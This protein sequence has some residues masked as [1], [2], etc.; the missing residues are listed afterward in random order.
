LN[1]PASSPLPSSFRDPSGHLFERDGVLY[2]SVA[3]RYAAH[4]DRLMSSGLYDRLVEAQL[5]VPHEE[6]T[7]SADAHRVLRPQRIPFVSYP[8]EW[9]FG[10]LRHAALATLRIQTLALEHGMSL[11]DASAYNIQFRDAKPCL[12]DTLSFEIRDEPRP[13]IAYRQFCEHFLAPLALM[14]QRD[15]RLNVLSA[16]FLDG[17]P[18]DLAAKLLPL[19][20][21]L[22]PA[23][24]LHVFAHARVQRNTGATR[25][26]RPFSQR[27]MRGLIE[28]LRGAVRAL[29]YRPRG[30]V[31]GDYYGQTNYE[32]S[33]EATKQ[34]L[35][36][37]MLDRIA[38][39]TVWDLGANDGRYS[40]LASERGAFTVAFDL[41]PA[42]VEA[43]YRAT[44]QGKRSNLLHLRMDLSNPSPALGW[45]HRERDSLLDRGPADCVLALALIHHLAIGNNVPWPQ[46]VAFFRRASRHL[47]VEF[48]P[49]QDSQ[50]VR[51]LASREDIFEAYDAE[52]FERAF[53][54]EFDLRER[55]PI[56][57]SLRT[58]YRFEAK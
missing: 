47:I 3:A 57:G 25:R 18:L 4:Y 8:Y 45:A 11:K 52:H 9:C 21:R 6:V 41:D 2:R 1:R 32:A 19:R 23:L 48:V 54:R 14:A 30:T 37:A 22:R 44:R 51:M 39:R 10:M 55:L 24:A 46:L 34:R 38:P 16:A 56:E 27:A 7:P 40:R 35:V 42:A 17:I 28:S 36:G 12:I 20:C 13:W 5:L 15:A 29:H 31:W 43:G 53:A 50:V 49:K 58:L 33:A 26:P